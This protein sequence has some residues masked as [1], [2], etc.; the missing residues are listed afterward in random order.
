MLA[1]SLVIYWI[2]EEDEKSLRS[3]MLDCKINSVEG[4]WRNYL[5]FIKW[6]IWDNEQHSSNSVESIFTF[7][8]WEDSATGSADQSLIKSQYTRSTHRTIQ[9]ND[10]S[11]I[12]KV[13]SDDSNFWLSS[14]QILVH[15]TYN[16]TKF[17][18]LVIMENGI[19]VKHIL[20]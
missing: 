9:V 15:S 16:H 19:K 18:T 20:F 3:N 13:L 10:A 5:E 7:L 8:R 12:W 14:D 6:F 17:L 2:M 11:S 1:P 4:Q